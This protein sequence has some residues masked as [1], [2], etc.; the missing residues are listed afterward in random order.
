MKILGLGFY[1][2]MLASSRFVTAL[3]FCASSCSGRRCRLLL[4]LLVAAS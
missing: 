2:V 3:L 4:A 1:Q